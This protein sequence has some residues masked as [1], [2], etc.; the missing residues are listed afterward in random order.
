[1]SWLQALP[2][3]AL[4]MSYFNVTWPLFANPMPQDLWKGLKLLW[5]SEH[6][7]LY[8]NPKAYH[9]VYTHT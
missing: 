5:Q 6:F 2:S 8:L 4:N 3:F 9:H 7:L 1:M